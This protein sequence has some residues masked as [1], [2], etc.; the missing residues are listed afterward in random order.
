MTGSDLLTL[1]MSRLGNRSETALRATCLSEMTLIQETLEQSATLPWFLISEELSAVTP[2]DGV[3]RR[4]AVPAGFLREV[5][6]GALVIIDSDGDSHVLEKYDYDACIAKYGRDETST[7]P[8]AYALVG[9]YF[10]LFPIPTVELTLYIH[11]YQEDDAPADNS[12]ENQ[13]LKYASDLLMAKTG[14]VVAGRHL[15]NT[16]LETLFTA[17]IPPAENRLYVNNVARAEAN[18][19]R[20]MGE[21]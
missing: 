18:R 3:E 1:L 11:C 8:E 17:D 10:H 21:S 4:V 14:K 12:T 19:D 2:S 5:D 15:R 9:D 6:E 20:Q 16:E 13:W 7:L